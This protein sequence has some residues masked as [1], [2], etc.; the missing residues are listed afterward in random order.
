[1]FSAQSLNIVSFFLIQLNLV[2][3]YQPVLRKKEVVQPLVIHL[4]IHTPLFIKA[5]M[6]PGMYV[7][8]QS[9]E[10]L[11]NHNNY[12]PRTIIKSLHKSAVP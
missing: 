5:Y 3:F 10:Q 9:V 4:V 8:E 7:I 12:G 2:V 6:L 11:Q 1:M